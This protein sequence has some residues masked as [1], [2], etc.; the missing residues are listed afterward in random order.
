MDNLD[1]LR[2][3]L[4]PTCLGIIP[5]IINYVLFTQ[6]FYSTASELSKYAI[7]LILDVINQQIF[8][9]F[10]NCLII[11]RVF[12]IL[13]SACSNTMKNL[14][15]IFLAVVFYVNARVTYPNVYK[16]IQTLELTS[17]EDV[18][19]PLILTP[20]LK[21]NKIEEARQKSTVNI[22]GFETVESYSGFFTVDENFDSNLFFWFF[23]SENDFQN[24]PVLL[25]LQGGPGASSLYAL[26][27]E[28]GPL[29]V[30][31]G[32]QLS[33]R[34]YSWTKNHSV[35]YID[36]PAGTGFSFTNG[37]YAQNET[38][39]GEDLYQAL[40]QFFT[41]FPEI[42]ENPFFVTGESY[43]GKYIPAIG[44]AIYLHRNT[45]D[46]QI[47]L[48]GLLIGDGLTDPENQI[49][50][51]GNYLYE[52]GFIDQ[53]G[54]EE[55]I[56][57]Q[58]E[59]IQYI[60]QN[61]FLKAFDTFDI[62]LNGDFTSPT[63]FQNLTGFSSYFNYLYRPSPDDDNSYE[64]FL[65]SADVRKAIHVGNLS[66]SSENVEENLREDLLQSVAPWVAELLSNYRMLFFNG[67]LD[68]IVA[69]PLTINFLNNLEFSGSDEYKTAPRSIWT[70]DDEVAGYV[71]VA[72]NLTEVLVRNS[73]HM[74][75]MDQP[76]WAYDLVYKFLYFKRINKTVKSSTEKMFRFIFIAIL[77]VTLIL[78]TESRSFISKVYPKF[79]QSQPEI[80]E[81]PGVPVI[82]TPLIES[83]KIYDARL[84]SQVQFNGFLGKTS[85]SG[86]FTVD[87][88]YESNLFFWYFPCET[89]DKDAPLLL[90]LQGGP[91]ATSLIGIFVEN[92]PF[93]TKF[94]HG[95]RERTT[96]WTKNH[97]VIYIDNPVG[98]G[99][100]FTTGGYAQNQ[101][102]VGEHIY[103]ALKQFF[104]VF[105]EE[106][107]KDFYITGESYAGKYI[108]AVAYTIYQKNSGQNETIN[109]K[110]LAI[111]DG[112]CDPIN[113][114]EYADYLYQIGLYDASTRDNIKNLEKQGLQMIQNKQFAEAARFFD[115]LMDG[116]FSNTTKFKNA[117]GFD[118]YDNFLY[119][120]D[121][122]NTGMELMA[123]YIVQDDVRAAIHVGNATFNEDSAVEENLLED[124]MQSVTPWITELLKHYKILFYNGQLD[125]IV[126]YPLTVNFLN[127]LDFNAATEYQTAARHQW[128]VDSNIAGYVKQAGNLTEILVRNAGHMVPAD[129]PEWAL[130]MITR[131]SHGS[132][133]YITTNSKMNTVFFIFGLYIIKQSEGYYKDKPLPHRELEDV[134]EPLIV[135][136]YIENGSINEA[137]QK[138]KVTYSEL[139]KNNLTSYSGYFT[140]DKTYN[141]NLFFWFFL[142]ENN[143]SEDPVILWLQGGPGASSLYGLFTE[144]G[145]YEVNE[146]LELS[147][148]DYSWTRDHSV[149]FIDNPAGTGFSFT[150]SGFAQNETKV[151]DD[152]YSALVQF[153]T[154]FPDLQ[155][156]DF[157]V[158]GESYGGKYVPSISYTIHK[159]NPGADL[160]I[161]LQGFAIGNPL[162]DPINQAD[163]GSYMYYLGLIDSNLKTNLKSLHAMF[164]CAIRRQEYEK[165]TNLLETIR[166]KMHNSNGLP[167]VYNHQA[168]EEEDPEYFA[169]YLSQDELRPQVHVGNVEYGISS[170]TVYDNL[171]ADKSKSIAP[172]IE[173]LLNN[174]RAL[175][176]NGQL[177]TA[178]PYPLMVN[179]L[180]KLSFNGHDEYLAG[181]RQIWRVGDEIAGY[182]KTGGYLTEVLVR[183]AGHMVPTFQPKWSYDLIYKFVRNTT[184]D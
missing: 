94:E 174:Y 83:G 168:I 108:P 36:N 85:F 24:D 181:E 3:T 111:G 166:S 52:L 80:G 127:H 29:I 42:A 92:G 41:L 86:Y 82:L 159:N 22:T 2:N 138:A 33:L 55:F 164:T 78:D 12:V 130:D 62:L 35:L 23:P 97:S 53:N 102:I 103:R 77:L 38:K 17:D 142:S 43:A 70:V 162:S 28:N 177:D 101:T 110:G 149:L 182:W 31:N 13:S 95:L 57:Y 114:L 183:D 105:P 131:F 8:E 157:Y 16:P 91:G 176:Y 126:G 153:F 98:T 117:T 125:I 26:F 170:D 44:Y 46:I 50:E 58:N 89:G 47:N 178:D 74:V 119:P 72:A 141:S 156:N 171:L 104:T 173:E 39:V 137:Q 71:K 68:I 109:L 27:C 152:L 79:K 4:L 99:Y 88:T 163:Y 84:A 34:E 160:K 15:F 169:T 20:L 64:A 60:Q 49:S 136:P 175:F 165:A 116:D 5:I 161:N 118:N 112:F 11:H 150:D 144:N 14:V 123:K 1:I 167:N 96:S 184:L 121:P 154:L 45:E 63:V 48:K 172:W 54:K 151:G 61:D 147:Y 18:G 107:K 21:E 9:T 134:G 75:P 87:K 37:G 10:L 128:I 67:Q 133:V 140:V 179:F 69:Y 139:T 93:E 115:S 30:L 40:V 106:K 120:I 132:L 56:K 129:Q 148:R 90:W 155:N 145:P 73:G 113:Q 158:T 7:N 19:D 143:P 124:L 122:L 25:W 59:T 66:Y 146:N 100:S 76:K 32:D 135:T 180:K 51:Y 81:F 6:Q 65:Q